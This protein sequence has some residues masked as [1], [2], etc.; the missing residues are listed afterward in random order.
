LISARPKVFGGAALG[1]K[2]DR[3]NSAALLFGIAAALAALCGGA[4]ARPLTAP[5]SLGDIVLGGSALDAVRAFGPPDLV[6]TVDRGHEWRW[7][8]ARGLDRDLLSDDDLSVIE[9]LIARPKRPRRG[10]DAA[11]PHEWPALG[12][13][14]VSA[15]ALLARSGL[16]PLRAPDAD[17]SLW[18]MDGAVIACELQQ[19]RVQRILAM[20]AAAAGRRGYLGGGAP[21]L[22]HRAPVLEHLNAL[23]YPHEAIERHATGVVVVRVSLDAAGKVREARVVVS[24]GNAAIDAAEV[25]TMRRSAFEAARC[26]DSPCAGVY[27]DREDYELFD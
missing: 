10:A 6:Q 27:L 23:G 17:V 8:D 18:R 2:R 21:L 15:G 3:G 16:T 24:S 14:D 26:G 13:D 22:R 4:A 9:I 1:A 5:L 7:Y 12:L 19:R 20:D 25:E 11:Q